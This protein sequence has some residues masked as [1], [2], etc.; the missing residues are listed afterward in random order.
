MFDS[1]DCIHYKWKNYL[2]AWQGDFSYR[3]GKKSIILKTIEYR[4][5][6]L[7]TFF[8][9][10]NSN[11]DLNVLNRSLLVYNILTSAAYNMILELMEN[12]MIDTIYLQIKLT[13]SGIILCKAFTCPLMRNMLILQ[14]DKKNAKKIWNSL[15]EFC[16]H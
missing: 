7:D 9:L 2:V 16:N 4:V 10:L 14:V 3:N 1:L 13:Y 15:L 12:I 8:E 11:N 5:C 6:T